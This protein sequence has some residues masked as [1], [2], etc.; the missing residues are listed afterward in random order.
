MTA[1]ASR[2]AAP[3]PLRP[4]RARPGGLVR[5]LAR[6]AAATALLAA[7]AAPL[8]P[9]DWEA[10]RRSW[11]YSHLAGAAVQLIGLASL[12][13]AVVRRARLTALPGP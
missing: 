5:M 12:I 7:C 9:A 6:V 3:M 8:P 4:G 1:V 11:E 2:P 10:L 13:L